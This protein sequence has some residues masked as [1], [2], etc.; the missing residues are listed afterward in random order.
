[1]AGLGSGNPLVFRCSRCRRRH[2]DYGP[3][4]RVHRV[5]LTGR[6]RPNRAI[7]GRIA[8]SPRM[9]AVIREY[10]CQDCGHVGWSAHIGLRPSLVRDYGN[11]VLHQL[12]EAYKEN[13]RD[14]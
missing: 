7:I 6:E 4:G 3:H 10:R 1:V 12:N 8:C 11:M 14:R 2:A 5:T 13:Y 9:D